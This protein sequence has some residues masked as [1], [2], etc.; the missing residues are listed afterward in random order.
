MD[1]TQEIKV[2]DTVKILS[3]RRLGLVGVVTVVGLRYAMVQISG[4]DSLPVAVAKKYLKK[5]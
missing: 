4:E 3:R 2:G 1:T 5:V